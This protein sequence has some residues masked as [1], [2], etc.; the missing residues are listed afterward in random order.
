M[1][2]VFPEKGKPNSFHKLAVMGGI[3]PLA[4]IS[5]FSCLPVLCEKQKW[6]NHVN[7]RLTSVNSTKLPAM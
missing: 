1:I 5:I 6:P 4:K 7:Y 3:M 2:V